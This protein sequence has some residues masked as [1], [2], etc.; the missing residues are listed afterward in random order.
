MSEFEQATARAH[1]KTDRNG[2]IASFS[3]TASD[4]PLASLGNTASA[5]EVDAYV[6]ALHDGSGMQNAQKNGLMFGLRRM[7]IPNSKVILTGNIDHY[8]SLLVGNHTDIFENKYLELRMIL[9]QI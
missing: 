1:R 8:S 3:I 2:G 5:V 4:V 7:N 6:N 9:S